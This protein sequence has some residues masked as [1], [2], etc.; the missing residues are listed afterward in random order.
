VYDGPIIDPHHHLWD[1]SM[2]THPWLAPTSKGVPLAGLEKIRPSYLPDS[3]RRDTA[4][5]NVVASVHIEALWD[6]SDPVGETRWLDTLDK[7]GGV[8][9]RYIAA[10]PLG[11]ERAREIVK[12]QAGFERV[13]GVRGIL[14]HHPDSSKS[15]VANPE[16]AYDPRWR[17]DV[18]LLQE[19]GL[20]LEL[21]MYP[22]QARAV[23]DLAKSFPGL[24][25]IVNHCGSPIDRDTA[26]MQRWRSGLDLIAPCGNVALKI[27]NPGAYDPEWTYQSIEAVALGCISAFGPDRCMFGTDYPVSRLNMTI[28]E[29][30][31]NFKKATANLCLSDQRALFHDNA[32]RFYRL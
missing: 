10:A 9:V 6:S 19:L 13:V 4:P 20:H 28:D 12:E 1:E 30:F 11:S 16:L 23:A 31:S 5:H 21:M 15:F 26:G 25:I 3:Y 27:S 8:A 17:A 32:M 18:A 7:R 14:S 24:Q 29:I 2:G 22:Y